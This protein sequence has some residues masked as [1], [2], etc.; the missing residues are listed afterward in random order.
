MMKLDVIY[1]TDE[2]YAMYTGVSLVSLLDNN[3]K[4]DKLNIHILDNAVTEESKAKLISLTNKYGRNIIFHNA[5]DLFNKLSDKITMKST[6]T[7]TAYACCFMAYLLD[8]TLDKVLYMD[9]DS[10]ICGDLSELCTIDMTD[11]YACG[12]L[13]IAA[14]IVREKIGFKQD[15]TYINSGFLYMSLKNIREASLRPRI[16]RFI[17]EVIPTSMHNDQDVVN[18]VYKGHIKVLPL[19]FNVITPLYEK[20][21]K[22]IEYYYKLSYYY[23]EEEVEEAK[24]NPTFIHFT[25]SFV[26]RPWV[27]GCKHPKRLEWEKYKAMTEWASFPT[28]RD[29]RSAKRKMIDVLFRMCN[30]RIFSTLVKTFGNKK[31]RV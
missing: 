19:K 30:V 17:E 7:I 18:G 26:K 27:S 10:L 9:G 20:K 12:V 29:T 13:D 11:I 6:Q 3:K 25:A 15:D 22:E 8:E 31:Q 16:I 24:K 23:S 21:F 28:K 2:N 4:I 1:A 5:K 14:P